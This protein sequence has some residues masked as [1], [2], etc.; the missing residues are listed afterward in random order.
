M[1]ITKAEAREGDDGGVLLTLGGVVR[2]TFDLSQ[3]AAAELFVDLVEILH[4]R[5]KKRELEKASAAPVGDR[6]PGAS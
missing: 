5:L 3:P 1:E 2:T 4:A 6:L